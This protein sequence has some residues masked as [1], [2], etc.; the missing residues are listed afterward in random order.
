M[1][2]RLYKEPKLNS[3]VMVVGWPGIGNIGLIAVDT[4]RS[5]A[6]AEEFGEIESWDF[7]YPKKVVIKKGLLEALEFPTNKF[8]F[9]RHEKNDLV[10]FIGEEQPKKTLS[11]YAE[12]EEAYRMANFVLDVASKFGCKMIYTSGAAVSFIHHTMKSRVWAVPNNKI[13]IKEL[14]K[15]PNTVLMSQIEGRGGQGFISGLNGLLLGV[16]RKRGFKGIC[17]MGEIPIYFQGLPIP[18]PKA[19]RSVLEVFSKVLEIKV[20]FVRFDELYRDIEKKIE[21][22]YN[23]LPSE[24]KD[25]LDKLK[26]LAHQEE[27]ELEPMTEENRKRLWDEI[28]K[29]LKGSKDEGVI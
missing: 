4:L 28:S 23:K 10:F 18:Y 19:S 25:R 7:F 21:D 8:Y 9:K 20:D 26:E 5:T 17:L 22:I 27:I 1:G 6:Q 2:I 3:P 15:Y 13:L 29:F 24:V 11:G 12:G 14:E 16:A